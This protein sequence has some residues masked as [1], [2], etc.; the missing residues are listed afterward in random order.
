MDRPVDQAVDQEKGRTM[1]DQDLTPLMRQ[2]WDIKRSH[3]DAILFFRVGD[4][5]EMFYEDA[6]EA[7]RLLSITLTSR[8][9]NRANPVPLCGV[10]YHAAMGYIDKLLKIGKSVALCEQVEDPQLAKGLVRREVVRLYT[11]GTLIDPEL[12]SPRESNY[13]AAVAVSAQKT[14]AGQFALSV[15]ELSTGVFWVSEFESGQGSQLA[16]EI[17]RVDPQELLVPNSLP[18]IVADRLRALGARLRFIKEADSL[19]AGRA[20]QLLLAHFRVASLEGFGCHQLTAG[21]LAA[22]TILSYLRATQPGTSL[23]HLS[24]LQHRTHGSTMHMDCTTMTTLE[25]VC[26]Q[27]SDQQ[28]DTHTLLATLDR[29]ATPMGHRLLREWIT[30]PLVDVDPIRHRQDAVG[31]LCKAPQLRHALRELFGKILDLPR[32]GSRIGMKVATPR[33]L[34]A[35]HGSLEVLPKVKHHLSTCTTDLLVELLQSWDDLSDVASNIHH[36][37]RQEAPP[38]TREGDI[39]KDGWDPQIDELR[40][41]CREGRTWILELEARERAASGIDSLKIRFNQ[42]FGYYI[43]ITKTRLAKAP[44]HYIRKQTLTNAERFTTPELKRL[45]DQV[46]GA[47]TRLISLEAARFEEF[48]ASLAPQTS[49]LLAMAQKVATLDVLLSFSEVALAHRYIKPDVTK[50]GAIEILDGRHPVVERHL[51]GDR[52]VPNDTLLNLDDHRILVLTGPNMA[53]KSTYLRQVG[54]IV[55]MAQIGS[56]VPAKEARI[57]MVDR[58]FTRVGAS[59][60]LAAGQSTFMVEMIETANILNSATARS[61]ILL[62]EIGRGTSTY[63][64]LSIAWA[65]TEYIHDRTRLG[66]RTLFATHYHEMTQLP[67][68]RDGIRNYHVAVKERDGTVVFLRKI[69]EG[70]ADRSYGIHVARLAGLPPWVIHRAEEVLEQLEREDAREQTELRFSDLTADELP[71]AHPILDEVRQMD[72]FS[73]TPLEALNRLADLQLRLQHEHP[74]HK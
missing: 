53:G 36:A 65:V 8:E 74:H 51:V 35:L 34:H 21:L 59:D 3:S 55:L 18:T 71:K 44:S 67:T 32:L 24:R 15:A 40:K 27:G 5:Y 47:E 66:A 2:Y 13:V 39:F 16:D 48:R 6:E 58:I 42:V 25:L 30:Q 28:H 64:G 37:I 23:A 7:S 10:P 41:T 63:D 62:D 20:Q 54:L 69:V 73:L 46:V 56:F 26:T 50:S 43:E 31:E 14:T 72:L 49:R 52:F 38:T 70:G 1:S 19:D 4:F 45:E 60:N 12:L 11:P 61:L 68:L 33:D 22:G 9:K 17:A 57:G 29:T